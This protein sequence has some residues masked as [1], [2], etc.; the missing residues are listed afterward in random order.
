MKSHDHGALFLGLLTYDHEVRHT[1]HATLLE[2]V[3]HIEVLAL[4]SR[5]VVD[6]KFF[7]RLSKVAGSLLLFLLWYCSCLP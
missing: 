5:F 4:D 7:N 1:L 3:Y 2:L 6:S